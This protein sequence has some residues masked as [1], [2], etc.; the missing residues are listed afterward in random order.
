[1]S[2]TFL[3]TVFS[4]DAT[5]SFPAVIAGLAEAT[6]ATGTLSAFSF[7]AFNFSSRSWANLSFSARS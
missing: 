3:S 5:C 1:M 4:S 7:S 6:A 2:D